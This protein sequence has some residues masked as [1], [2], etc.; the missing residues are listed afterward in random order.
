[1]MRHVINISNFHKKVN[2]KLFYQIISIKS[3]ADHQKYHNLIHKL[4]IKI[5]KNVLYHHL[6]NL[7]NNYLQNVT[8]KQVIIWS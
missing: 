2:I 5:N 7:N 3:M 6:R 4:E 1:M 8:K